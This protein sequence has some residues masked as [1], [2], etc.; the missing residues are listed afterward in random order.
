M[1]DDVVSPGLKGWLDK[2]VAGIGTRVAVVG[3]GLAG[4][5]VAWQLARAGVGVTL[6]EMKPEHFSQAHSSPMLAELVCSNSLRSDEPVAATGLLKREM[7]TLGSL[8]LATAR[9][10]R[11]P[12]GKA[13]A[14][15][16]ER[17]AARMTER[18]AAEPF[19]RLER[20]KI[21]SLEDTA[22][23]G[24]AAVVIAVGPLAT[25]SL[26]AS[27]DAAMSNKHLYFYDAISP[28]VAAQSLDMTRIFPG[29]RYQSEDYDYLNCPLDEIAYRRFH[30]ALSAGEIMPTRDFERELHF[31]SCMPIEALAIRG[32]MTL[33]FGPFRSV[34]LI[35]PATGRCPFAVVQLRAEN[36]ER[37]YFNLV[38]CQT[39]LKYAEQERIFRMLPGLKQAE[40]V[41]LGSAHRNTYVNAP[42]V[43]DA[44]LALKDRPGVYLAGQITG[45]EG[46]M[47]SAACGLWVGWLLATKLTGRVL[48]T[49]P[50][51][52]ALGALLGYLREGRQPFTPSN[53][54]F[55]LTPE[56]IGCIKKKD[57]KVAYAARGEAA[58]AAWFAWLVQEGLTLES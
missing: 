21:S 16:R 47:E 5:E 9:E 18:I 37:T 36:R 31:E 6:F 45:V 14:V 10:T 35:D 23:T 19:I 54:H 7:A 15:D 56:I 44:E 29:S 28:I 27:L 13:L 12:A 24:Y 11:V 49:P 43:L 30:A 26:A 25:A 33:A 34:G 42:L 58:F 3:G 17:F 48:P 52:T 2:K 46:Y 1:Y 55:G 41:R 32:E 4:C 20:R 40:F 39:K 53:V 50:V 22:L 8:V 51:E 38:G 57:R